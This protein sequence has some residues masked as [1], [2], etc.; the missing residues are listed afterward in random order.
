MGNFF[1]A[2]YN[3]LNR[4]SQLR[5]AIL[6]SSVLIMVALS[7]R[8]NYVEDITSFFPENDHS[9]EV[10]KSLKAKD[11]IA[12]MVTADSC[13][14]QSQ[15]LL[16]DCADELSRRFNSEVDFTNSANF[17]A[18]IEDLSVERVSDFVYDYLPLF[19]SE[20]DYARME[21]VVTL[22]SISSVMAENYE[23][24]ISPIGSYISE[25]IYRDPLGIGSALLGELQS[26][27]EGFSYSIVDNYLFSEDGRTLICYIEPSE[28]IGGSSVSMLVDCIERTASEVSSDFPTLHIEYYGAP[29]IAEYNARQI[30]RDSLVTLNIAL[31]LVV[32]LLSFAFRNKYSAVLVLL[33]VIYGSI[34]SLSIISLV[35]GTISLIAVGAGSI[36]FGIALSYSIHLLSH[37]IHSKDIREVVRDLAYPLTVGSFTTIGAFAGLMFTSSEILQDLGLFASLTLIGTTLFVL[38]FLPHFIKIKG[39]GGNQSLILSA[40]DA[41]T[42]FMQRKSRPIILGIVVVTLVCGFFAG[43]V[44]FDSNM[45]NLNY[46]PEHLKSAG[47]RLDSFSSVG[48]GQ[49]SVFF[50][51]SESSSGAAADRYDKLCGLLDSLKGEDLVV[52]YSSIRPFVV[53]DSLRTERVVRWSEF[54]DMHNVSEVV[55]VMGGAAEELGFEADAFSGFEQMLS[56]DYDEMPYEEELS[57]VF[58]EWV[59]ASGGTY[60]FIAQVQLMDSSKMEVY[61]SISSDSQLLAADRSFFTNKMASDVGD[62]FTLV[63]YLSGLLVFGAMLLCY[64]RLE[65]TL[66]A[67]LPM[68]LSWIIILGIM[69]LC[70]IEFNIVTIILSTFI[71]GIGDDFSIFMMDGLLS[72]YKS[73]RAVLGQHK[74]AIF[75]SAFTVLVGMGVLVFAEHPAMNSLGVISLLGILIVVL[76]SYTIQPAI[77]R[78]FIA[79][80][81]GRGG[82]PYTILSL[83]NTLYA[84]GL[85]VFGCVVVQV[86]MSIIVPLPIGKRRRVAFIH[87]LVHKFCKY[88]LRV[89]VTTRLVNINEGG[90]T[91]KTPSVVIANHQSFIDILMLLGMNSKFI[92]VTNDWV[93]NSPIFG[94][95]VRYLGFFNTSSGYE[96]IVGSLR[97]SVA[98]GYSIVIFPEGT[99]SE[100]SSVKRFHK[101]A[102]YLAQEL[103]LDITPI[104]IYGNGLVSSK[105]QGLYIK[106]GK[107]VS[108]ILPRIS[109]DSIVYGKGYSE[110]AKLITRYFREEYRL[111]YEEFN[112]AS[113]PYYRD[114]LLKN[115]IYKGPVVEW[116]MRVKVRFEGWYDRYDRLL[117][118]EGLIVDL[119]CGYGAMS[120][121]LA[122][123]SDR[124]RIVGY[125]YDEEKILLA[126]NSFSANER[127]EFECGDIRTIELPEA[128]AFV[129]SDVLHYLDAA[130]QQKI[131]K[132]AIEKLRKGGVLIIKD[133][134]SSLGDRHHKTL[135]S[136]KWSTKITKFNKTNGE[137][138]FLSREI[139]ERIA[140]EC[141]AE[142]KCIDRGSRLS[143]VIFII[144]KN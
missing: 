83:L 9:S 135:Q 124:R 93:W 69:A 144:I 75:F 129:I 5:W 52:S 102:F 47:E 99:R 62:N 48:S 116:Y 13:D 137:L 100:D 82:F 81:T 59:S 108:K 17:V 63:L 109:P 71:F 50:I 66:M 19:L 85:F 105:G 43:R 11:K 64:G 33:P 44:G 70:G 80:P 142:V 92:M 106:R 118:R 115:Y 2:I 101:G 132:S 39:D 143:N 28:G 87:T 21:R 112:R 94:R 49:S 41:F 77:F 67:F 141:N 120:Y 107:L 139:V 8:V 31:L 103:E 51:A 34:F 14:V 89:M 30:K 86:L 119:G 76:V 1:V 46:E 60:S 95:I 133:G 117:P 96:N 12:V 23:R 79:N 134:D 4:H 36:I 90:E 7:L 3:Y 20:D 25:Y 128:D 73:R 98:R 127:I 27:G 114:A 136:E 88:F 29:I 58:S 130:S 72:E 122:L 55:G 45:M 91:F 53:T 38:I 140:A 32:V 35:K 138:S 110:R 125:D 37:T 18:G 56:R 131:I 123:L 6:I 42:S 68:F 74:T 61:S 16:M 22:D 40:V 78:L 104:I 54:W 126:R 10:F 111:L 26:L 97:E 57:S 65:L 24:L 15:Y 84:F 113:N 121:M